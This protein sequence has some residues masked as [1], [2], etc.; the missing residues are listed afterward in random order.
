MK[1]IIISGAGGFLGTNIIKAAKK[2]NGLKVT[3]IT[4]REICEPNAS[5]I[6]TEEF[7]SGDVHFDADDIFINCLFPTNAD[8]WRMAD[9]LDKV[10][11]TI[12]MAHK[13]GIGA[14]VNI[15]SQSV[16]ASKRTAP[17]DE[18]DPLCLESSYAVGKYS[19]EMYTNQVFADRPHTNIRLASLIGVGY[20]QRIINRMVMQALKGEPLK[21]IGGMQRYG[22]LDVRDAAAGLVKLSQSDPEQWAEV[23]NLGRNDSCTLLD[24]VQCVRNEVMQLIG[25][26]VPFSVAEGQDDRNSAIN[27]SRFMEH[28]DWQAVYSLADT[29]AWII[30]NKIDE[31]E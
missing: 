25:R 9:G 30:R 27:A 1:R 14:F 19:M 16:Y 13:S 15:S 6:S 5:V 23:Y 17:A 11:Q 4:S 3:A 8:G 21:V 28:F 18:T 2:Q 10:C 7:L 12:R 31:V 29:T 20:D 24:V 26:E 22:F